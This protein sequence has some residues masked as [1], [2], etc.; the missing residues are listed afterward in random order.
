MLH[1]RVV[2]HF[3]EYDTPSTIDNQNFAL[4]HVQSTKELSTERQLD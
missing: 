1:N 2:D 3:K 4:N